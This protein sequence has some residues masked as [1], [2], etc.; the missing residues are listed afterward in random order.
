MPLNF[1]VEL[2]TDSSLNEAVDSLID[3]TGTDKA[4]TKVLVDFAIE[5]ADDDKSWDISFDFNKIAKLLINEN[6]IKFIDTLKDKSLN[7]F[8]EFK[9]N[10]REQ[11]KLL[12]GT[13]I[14]KA[15]GVLTFIEE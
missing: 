15:Q 6:D 11:V 3:K 7:E 10:L 12:E 14:K 5:K 1:E 13:I 9:K 2:D 8:N 4:L